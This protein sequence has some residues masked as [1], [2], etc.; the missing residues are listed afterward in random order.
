MRDEAMEIAILGI[1]LG[2]NSCSLAGSDLAGKVSVR[3]RM[4]RETVIAFCAKRWALTAELS[5]IMSAGGGRSPDLTRAAKIICHSPRLLQRLYRSK[6]V[7]LRP[8]LVRKRP[9][10]AVLAQAI[11]DAAETRRSFLRSGPVSPF[12]RCAPI[13]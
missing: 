3:R 2:K 11:D 12:G 6:K 13:T 9:L 1:D 5:I 8:A 7:G 10:P 4:Q